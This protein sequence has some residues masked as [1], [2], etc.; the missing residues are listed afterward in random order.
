MGRFGTTSTHRD[1][2]RPGRLW[3]LFRDPVSP[4]ARASLDAV[5]RDIAPEFR[6]ANQMLGRHEEGCGATIGAMPR[7]D[8]A[9]RGCYLSDGANRTPALPVTDVI[10]QLDVLRRHLG[11]WGNVQLTDGEVSLRDPDEVIAILRHARRIELIPMLMTHGDT[12][13]RDPDLLKRFM[14]EGGLE[15]ISFHVDTTQRGRRDRR[16]RHA[17][18]EAGLMPL[19][20]RFADLVRQVRRE[21]GHTLRV[22]STVTVTADN[23]HEVGD[24]VRFMHAHADVFRMV[25]FLP[26][27]PVGRTAEGIGR[28]DAATLWVEIERGLD[29][30]AT[31]A[32]RLSQNRWLM[33]HPDCSRFVI[34]ASVKAG[35]G[36]PRFLP[37]SPDSSAADRVLLEAIF[38]R[39][40]GATFR[41]DRPAEAFARLAGMA[42]RAPGLFLWHFP[43]AAWDWAKRLSPDAPGSLIRRTV[44][45]QVAVHRFAI[46]AHHFMGPEELASETGQARLAHCAFQVAIDGELHSMCEVN[47]TGLREA[48]YRRIAREAAAAGDD[49]LDPAA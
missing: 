24:I 29:I 13:L 5:W 11:P 36:P 14:V 38:D 32:G 37:V 35:D 49:A 4:E 17:G 3:R 27:A 28:I 9:C 21:T 20:A 15:E 39:L 22:A 31:N 46:T 34:G 41:A 48:F 43:R 7:C 25:G 12:F 8:F 1:P 23:L 45:G 42:V 2:V 10:A 47:A 26:V 16:F 6:T 40:P 30:E 18:T 19:R 33:G 44:T